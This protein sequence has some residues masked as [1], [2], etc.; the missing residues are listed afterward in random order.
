MLTER[1]V[2]GL[3]FEGDRTRVGVVTYQSSPKIEF[4]LNAYREKLEV[5]NAI[6]F[7]QDMRVYGT[8]T[9]DALD[10]L[11]SDFFI[12]TAGERSGVQNVAIVMTDGRSNI[13]MAETLVEADKAKNENIRLMVVGIGAKMDAV[14]ING[15]ASDP[16]SDNT[17]QL[18]GEGDLQT[19]ADQILDQLCQ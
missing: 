11:R 8:N 13:K 7:K 18:P 17:F 1:I 3:N 4:P 12:S 15:I 14:E 6:A 19:V 9:A 2:M 5:M 10:V 16:D